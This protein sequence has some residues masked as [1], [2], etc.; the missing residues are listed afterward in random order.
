MTKRLLEKG[1]RVMLYTDAGYEASNE[2]Y[3]K[4][5]YVLRGRLCEL[6]AVKEETGGE[7]R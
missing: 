2:C 4:I 3:R 6:A 5:G 7:E 1:F